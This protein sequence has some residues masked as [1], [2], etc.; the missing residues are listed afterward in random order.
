MQNLNNK[1]QESFWLRNT[2]GL[3][4]N[5][6]CVNLSV[7]VSHPSEFITEIAYCFIISAETNKAILDNLEMKWYFSW[8]GFSFALNMFTVPVVV[9]L[10]R[11]DILKHN[12]STISSFT[13]VVKSDLL[14]F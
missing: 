14:S 11:I 4:K 7:Y 5:T 13:Q 12:L 1:P 10:F 6:Q 9:F 2:S 3:H 8:K